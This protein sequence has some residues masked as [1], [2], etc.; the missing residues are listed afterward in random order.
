MSNRDRIII[1]EYL[2]IVGRAIGWL[3]TLIR[4]WQVDDPTRTKQ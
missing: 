4:R 1:S 3:Y 2:E